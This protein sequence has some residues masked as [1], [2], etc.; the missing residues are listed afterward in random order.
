MKSIIDRSVN[1][2]S[3]SLQSIITQLSNLSFF[4]S[5]FFISFIFLFESSSLAMFDE[6]IDN[7]YRTVGVKG[8]RE[9]GELDYGFGDSF[10]T[11]NDDDYCRRRILEPLIKTIKAEAYNGN[12]YA[13]WI[14]ARLHD[15]HMERLCDRDRE[16]LGNEDRR[17]AA[18]RWYELSVEQ[19]FHE[20]EYD[21]S[22]LYQIGRGVPQANQEESKRLISLAAEGGEPR[23]QNRFAYIY[24]KNLDEKMRW[25]RKSADQGHAE[26]YINIGDELVKQGNITQAMYCYRQALNLV[27]EKE[28]WAARNLC[29]IAK[30]RLRPFEPITCQIL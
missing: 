11:L 10:F 24:I 23:A 9:F 28:Y 14:I 5:L 12:A 17:Q 29:L 1:P 16:S 7:F 18:V 26:A 13:Q 15:I 19:G 27:S 3:N 30:N 6:A 21:L 20:A 8:K 25:F 4:I 2:L 22:V